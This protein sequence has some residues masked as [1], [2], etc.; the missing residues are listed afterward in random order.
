MWCRC[1]SKNGYICSFQMYTGKIGQTTE[2]N[3]GARVIKDLSEPLR[4]KNYHLYFDNLFFSPTLLAELLNF[5]IYCIGTMVTNRK[6]FPKFAS[7]CI[8]KGREHIASQVIDNKVRCF[9]C[10]DRKPV[11]SNGTIC[12]HTD[13]TLLY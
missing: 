12:D 13:I 3:F 11:A 2:K 9:I 7:K 5:K 6:H 8:R 4:G 1:D 10:G